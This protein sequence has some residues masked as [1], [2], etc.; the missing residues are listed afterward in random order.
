MEEST[1]N[2]Y[3][4]ESNHINNGS[5]TMLLGA[6]WCDKE[7]AKTLSNK[8]KLAK[9]NHGISNHREIKWTKVSQAKLEYYKSL[10]DI[11]TDNDQLKYRAVIVDKTTLDHEIFNQSEDD[12]YYKMQYYLV[13]N[14]AEK[15][16]GPFR[17]FIDYK[18]AYSNRRC[19]ELSRILS[20]K[21]SFINKNFTTQ[22]VAS[23]Q[24]NALQL[25]DLITGAV[26]YANKPEA[27]KKSSA[28]KDLVDYIEKRIG[29]KLTIKTPAALDKFNL[30]FWEPRCIR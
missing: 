27:E 20:N 10:I 19:I 13:R 25:A 30:F 17:I 24:V 26:M 1:I 18:D 6:I 22:P 29:Q 3:S 5:T 4:D 12:F 11:F 28:K 8:I 14:I 21:A 7:T 9:L 15:R 2:I 16:S 23:H